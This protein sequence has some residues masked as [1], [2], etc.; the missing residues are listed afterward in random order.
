MI[1][2]LTLEEIESTLE[3]ITPHIVITPVHRWQGA[4]L[5]QVVGANTEVYLKLELF[6][7][8]GTF[9]ARGAL[10]VML[11]LSSDE[12]E[13]GVTAVSAGNHAIAVAYAAKVLGVSARVVMLESANQFRIDAAVRLG[14][15]VEMAINGAEAFARAELL[16]AEEGRTMIHPFEGRNTSLGTA[17]VG[18]EWLRQSPQLDAIVVP[19]GGGGLMSGIASAAKL[20]APGIEVY[21]VEPIGADTMSRSLAAGAPVRMD[22]IDTIADSL[23]PPFTTPTTYVLCERHV[24]GW[25]L[26][27]DDQMRQAMRLL[28]EEMKLAVEPAGAAATAALC[29]PLK[30]RLR[31]R[32]VGV[33]VCGS[34]IDDVSFAALMKGSTGDARAS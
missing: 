33:L 22:E 20:L 9:K 8:T 13:H 11:N 2:N 25:V 24:D 4:Q 14:A 16:V 15:E 27:T 31:G 23:A 19:V 32:R 28:F 30:D 3:R 29:G 26:I 6:Q 21:G 1:E 34:N 12:K 17:T 5:A 7:V 18:L 10:N